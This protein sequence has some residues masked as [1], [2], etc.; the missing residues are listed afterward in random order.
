MALAAGPEAKRVQ[1][2]PGRRV[3][4]A[5]NETGANPPPARAP[6]KDR[7]RRGH[8]QQGKRYNQ[9]RR[10]PGTTELHSVTPDNKKICFAFQKKKCTRDA[11]AFAHVCAKCFGPHPF[12][13][14]PQAGAKRGRKDA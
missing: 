13:D 3:D 11:C 5:R 4:L 7:D 8:Q 14:C 2:D 9:A 12:E 10:T 1:H 6:R